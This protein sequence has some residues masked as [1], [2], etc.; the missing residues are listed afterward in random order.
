MP[1]VG[2]PNEDASSISLVDSDLGRFDFF[3]QRHVVLSSKSISPDWEVRD[4]ATIRFRRYF[5]EWTRIGRDE[6]R[7]GLHQ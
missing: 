6:K 7:L 3:L 2:S 1:G 4:H 5:R